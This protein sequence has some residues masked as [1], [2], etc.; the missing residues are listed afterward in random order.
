MFLQPM[1]AFIFGLYKGSFN[2][3]TLIF[4]RGQTEGWGVSGLV[5]VIVLRFL[6]ALSSSRRLVV[7]LLVGLSVGVC[8]KVTCRVFE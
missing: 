2:K 3:K 7:C 1:N 6:V 8:E 5:V 4:D